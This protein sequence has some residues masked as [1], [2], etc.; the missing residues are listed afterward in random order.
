MDKIINVKEMVEKEKE[1]LKE[2]IKEIKSKNIN[3]KLVVIIA[4]NLD[5]TKLY[6]R[7]KKRLAQELGIELKEIVYNE[8]VTQEEINKKI[9]DLNKDDKVHGILVQLP[10]FKHLNEEEI[11]YKI[12]KEKDV[13]CFN[14]YN[15]GKIMLGN[16]NLYPCTPK[17][18]MKI[19]ENLGENLEG[20]HA[21]VIGRS[22][23]VGKPIA[24]M[25]LSKNATVT[26]CHSKT[27]DLAKETLRADILIVAT[28][29]PHLVK[30]D[31]VKKDAI[32][33][34][35]G[36]NRVDGKV[37]GDVDTNDCLE[38]VK[39]ITKVPGGVGLT[40]VLSVMENLCALIEE[41]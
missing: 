23:I 20:K 13:D 1:K 3:P 18:I 11:I 21:V 36:I 15:L 28:G 6:V 31:M 8:N 5:S 32:V 38:K 29:V 40:T 39:Y 37:I 12:D 35:V 27:K 26:V 41:K 24:Q 14:P 19:L 33:I 4:N 2:K 17:G 25:L 7:N 22:N 16:T 10:L 9:G 34:D 30:K